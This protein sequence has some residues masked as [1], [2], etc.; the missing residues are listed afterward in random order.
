[1][2]GELQTQAGSNRGT[3]RYAL[4]L[5][6]AGR[7]GSDAVE[8][9]Q[10]LDALIAAPGDLDPAE[11]Q[12]A[13]A[14]RREFDA[15]ATRDAQL[16]QQRVELDQ[17]LAAANE[18]QA[19]AA[20]A[21]AAENARSSA[22]SPRPRPSCRPSPRWS[23]SCSSRPR[24]FHPNSLDDSREPKARRARAR[25]RRRSRTAAPAHDPAAL[26]EI[27]GR[28]ADSAATALSVIARF[29]PDLVITDLR[30][31]Q[32]DG[33]ALLRELKRRW[34]SLNVVVLTAHGTSRCRAGHPVRGLR[35]PHQAGRKGTA[36]RGSAPR[37]QDLR[38]RGHRGRMVRRVRDPQ[39]AGGERARHRPDG[40]RHRH[41]RADQWR[42][43]HGA[44]AA[45]TGH[46]PRQRTEGGAARRSRLFRLRGRARRHE[47]T[48]RRTGAGGRR[49]RAPP[50]RA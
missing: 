17:R 49:D 13:Q 3:L 25:G 48:H 8:A 10:L 47:A 14:M 11:L 43:R 50:G 4:A 40:G 2:L 20:Q 19:R 22:S 29:R 21:A 6:A 27:R 34:P 35:V 7:E 32:M 39:P 36:A 30:M 12:L 44:R 24:P 45:G 5:G 16:A 28:A 26:R 9:R 23:A 41:T 18:A 42:A 15:R 38:I 1:M 33:L 46:P 37:A 31:A